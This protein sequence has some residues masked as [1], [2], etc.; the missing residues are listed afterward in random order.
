MCIRDSIELEKFVL[1]KTEELKLKIPGLDEEFEKASADKMKW[2][3]K[4][5]N[6][7]KYFSWMQHFDKTGKELSEHYNNYHKNILTHFVP[8]PKLERLA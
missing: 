8:I 2:Q 7:E 6:L 5:K 3:G 1:A 4:S